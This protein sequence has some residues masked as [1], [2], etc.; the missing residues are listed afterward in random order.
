MSASKKRS[1][2]PAN[3]LFGRRAPFATVLIKPWLSVSQVTIRLVSLSLLRR[4]RIAAEDSISCVDGATIDRQGGF[5][6]RFAERRVRV[7]GAREILRAAVE[8]HDGDDLG[9]QLGGVRPNNLR[10]E[11]SI[12]LGVRDQFDEAIRRIARECSAIRAED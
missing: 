6:G 5:L 1:R 8:F 4:S 11:Q 2:R 10:A 12:R 3:G 9:D 7:H